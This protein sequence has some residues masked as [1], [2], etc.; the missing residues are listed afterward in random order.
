MRSEVA[1]HVEAS[2]EHVY[3]LVSDITRM[4][5]LA[6]DLPGKRTMSASGPLAGKMAD[7]PCSTSARWMFLD[8]R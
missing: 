2:P 8:V 5:E 1:I 6:C 3:D 7:A 4:G